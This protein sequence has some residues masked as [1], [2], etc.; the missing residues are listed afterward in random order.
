LHWLGKKWNDVQRELTALN[1]DYT[2]RITYPDKKIISRGDLRVV[3]VNRKEGKL[4]F[5]LLHDKYQKN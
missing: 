5:I 3:R 1:L 2:S 4:V